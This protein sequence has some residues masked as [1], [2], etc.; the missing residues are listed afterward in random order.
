LRSADVEGLACDP[1]RRRRERVADGLAERCRLKSHHQLHRNDLREGAFERTVRPQA[2]E[3]GLEKGIAIIDPSD[4]NVP[5]ARPPE[6]PEGPQP[7]QQSRAAPLEGR[8]ENVPLAHDARARSRGG[9]MSRRARRRHRFGR[10]VLDATAS[11][12]VRSA[13]QV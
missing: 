13:A 12:S 11:G 7:R 4:E 3:H 5:V 8:G 6:G 1:G 9:I 2:L 10:P